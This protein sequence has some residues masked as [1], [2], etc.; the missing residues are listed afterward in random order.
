LAVSDQVP[1]N[2]STHGVVAARVDVDLRPLRYLG[3]AMLALGAVL[4]H[5]PGNPGLPC[6][7]RTTTGVPC[8]LCGM[9]TSVKATMRGNVHAAITANPFGILAVVTAILLLV[10]PAWRRLSLPAGVL[11]G[12]VLVSW[13]F[14]LHR[15]HI[16]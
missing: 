7:L 2:P 8:P 9:T 5:L 16:V 11:I 4:P 1:A 14:Q 13:L 10:R 6:P 15:F 12:G 3:A